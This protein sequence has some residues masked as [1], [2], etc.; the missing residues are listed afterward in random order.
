MHTVYTNV[1]V[2]AYNI[3]SAWKCPMSEN[4]QQS[5]TAMMSK[6]K[7]QWPAWY[8]NPEDE[9]VLHICCH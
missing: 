4:N 2:Y 5:Y 3:V 6:K 7:Q 9:G 8:R 1:G